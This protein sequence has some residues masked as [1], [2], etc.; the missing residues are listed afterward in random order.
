MKRG[1]LT[2]FF[3]VVVIALSNRTSD[4]VQLMNEEGESLWI[5]VIDDD[6]NCKDMTEKIKSMVD[7]HRRLLQSDNVGTLE[8]M[9]EGDMDCFVHFSAPT[10]D[11]VDTIRGLPGVTSVEQDDEVSFFGE[12]WGRDRADQDD[13]P[14]DKKEYSPMYTGKGQCL[15]VI[16]TGIY[17]EHNDFTGRASY[18][19]DF[20]K[21]A[22][23]GDNN[24]HGTHCAS[25]AAGAMYGIAP[26]TE[27]IKGVKVLSG[28]GSGSSAGVI[29]GIQ[30]A[31]NDA[32]KMKKTCVLSLSLGGGAN[33]ALN[34]AAVDA[35]SKHIVVVAAGNSN[36]DACSGSPSGAG[37]S[38]ITVGSTKSDDF[39][40]SFSNFGPCVDIFGPGS[41]IRAAYIGSPSTTNVLSGT[42]MATPYIA[43][44]ALQMLQKHN[45][46]LDAAYNELFAVAVSGKLKD[47]GQ[48]SPNL[49]GRIDDYTGPPTPPTMK[50][51]MPPTLP[52]PT[53]CKL[54]TATGK[55]DICVEFE[56]SKFGT[57]AWKDTPIVAPIV[58]PTDELMCKNTAD[59]FK[60][61]FVL[62]KRGSCLFFDK[63]KNCE[64]QGALGVFIYN[65]DKGD[66][67][68]PPAYYGKGKTNLPSCMIG[69]NDGTKIFND[70]DMIHW[71]VYLG[72]NV[73]P[74]P[75]PPPTP[76][77]TA[78]P[79]EAPTRFRCDD[80][81]QEQ[82][83]K[84][85][86]CAWDGFVCYIKPKFQK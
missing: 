39:R 24:G 9:S 54:N 38:V 17:K 61:K 16:D 15:Y 2:N 59:D 13:L 46:D 33:A 20:I 68:F 66:V 36:T 26:E 78:S 52:D 79:T 64:Q 72:S 50:P 18:G 37:G 53:L 35:A 21:E 55:Y 28:G 75:S 60:G 12:E 80:N 83:K 63:V 11:I 67:I 8:E 1:T 70:N 31:V 82:C 73:E 30:W 7:G 29:K 43:G 76:L 10:G 5:A 51:T 25:T 84:E 71:G 57:Y 48:G 85:R 41:N 44:I 27:T 56:S 22:T 3:V 32:K 6:A 81:E 40:S 65:S 23:P 34:K 42:S 45:G 86:K 47:I 77:P 19:G 49:L 14:L 74:V 62:V 69:N 58:T 4:A